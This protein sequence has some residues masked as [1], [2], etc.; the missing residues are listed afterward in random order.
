MAAFDSL[1]QKTKQYSQVIL[2]YGMGL[3]KHILRISND[4]SPGVLQVTRRNSDCFCRIYKIAKEKA[5]IKDQEESRNVSETTP[6]QPGIFK[7][8]SECFATIYKGN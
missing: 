2:F 5:I 4:F 6:V 8:C 1:S 3:A 7:V